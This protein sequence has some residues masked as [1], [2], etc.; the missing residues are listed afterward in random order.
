MGTGGGEGWG[1]ELRYGELLR[2]LGLLA[3]ARVDA[4]QLRGVVVSAITEFDEI[5][6]LYPD[7]HTNMW[8]EAEIDFAED[9]NYASR[10]LEVNGCQKVH[11]I[12]S[13]EDLFRTTRSISGLQLPVNVRRRTSTMQ[14]IIPGNE[15]NQV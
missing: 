3:F 6:C 9:L 7:S 2:R 4:E 1:P 12:K 11:K 5:R 10:I 13:S 14:N 15:G 8:D